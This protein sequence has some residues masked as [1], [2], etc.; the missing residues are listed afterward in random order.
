MVV[1]H[2]WD[3]SVGFYNAETGQS[4]AKVTVGVRP[5]ELALSAD[6]RLAYITNYGVNS[7][8]QT[9][10]GG[11]TIS[12][13]DLGERKKSGEIELGNFHRPH[14]GDCRDG[15]DERDSPLPRRRECRRREY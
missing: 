4:L 6:R 8:T 1:V 14:G 5:H 13:V 9:E 15:D 7:Y 2:K 3:N 12:I 11:N 10:E